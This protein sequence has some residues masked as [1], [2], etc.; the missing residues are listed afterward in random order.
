MRLLADNLHWMGHSHSNLPARENHPKIPDRGCSDATGP[1][2]FFLDQLVDATPEHLQQLATLAGLEPLFHGWSCLVV[3][4]AILANTLFRD[5][6]IHSTA[7]YGASGYRAMAKGLAAPCPLVLASTTP[8]LPHQPR[9]GR[10]VDIQST[11]RAIVA[12]NTDLDCRSVGPLQRHP[13]MATNPGRFI[14]SIALEL[15][16]ASG[17][18]ASGNPWIAPRAKRLCLNPET[19][20]LTLA[21]PCPHSFDMPL[22]LGGATPPCWRLPIIQGTLEG[23]PDSRCRRTAGFLE[24]PAHCL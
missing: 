10:S 1:A 8:A 12:S 2:S 5:A 14:P 22:D 21:H 17:I 20:P 13:G 11:Q 18:A 3:F 4:T 24:Q 19:L 6:S 16:A 9:A 15:P 7:E 23:I